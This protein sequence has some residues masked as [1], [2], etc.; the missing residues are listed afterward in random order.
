MMK[1][2]WRN[3]IGN[4]AAWNSTQVD[5]VDNEI[6]EYEDMLTAD[7]DFEDWDKSADEFYLE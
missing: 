3:N 2:A 5:E 4:L 7:R 1:F 6:K